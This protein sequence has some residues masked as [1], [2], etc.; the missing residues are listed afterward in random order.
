MNKYDIINKIL[1]NLDHATVTGV[2]NAQLLL[3]SV[4]NL[5][6]LAQVMSK[7]DEEKAKKEEP[8]ED[9]PKIELVS[10]EE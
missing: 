10:A 2:A 5:Q 7:E 8:A 1:N 4:Q 6:L 3:D 9:E